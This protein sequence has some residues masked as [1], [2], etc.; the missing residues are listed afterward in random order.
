MKKGRMQ[1]KWVSKARKWRMG[2]TVLRWRNVRR[3]RK[4]G[5]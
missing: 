5:L 1:R 4:R 2:R 3:W